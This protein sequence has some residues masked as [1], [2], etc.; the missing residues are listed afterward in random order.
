VSRNDARVIFWALIITRNG[1]AREISK[2]DLTHHAV[3][4]TVT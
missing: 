2:W 1:Y 3:P 4:M